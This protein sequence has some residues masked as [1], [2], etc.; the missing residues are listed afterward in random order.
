MGGCGE[1]VVVDPSTDTL[2]LFWLALLVEVHHHQGASS[3]RSKRVISF[4]DNII[5]QSKT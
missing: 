2:L 4:K 3:V 5:N 1:V